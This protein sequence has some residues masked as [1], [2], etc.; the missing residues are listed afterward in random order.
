MDSVKSNLLFSN[1][2]CRI[3]EAY[4]FRL[5]KLVPVRAPKAHRGH[6]QL[7]YAHFTYFTFANN[8][9]LTYFTFAN[10]L[11]LPFFET[12]EGRK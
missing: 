3:S 5:F 11:Q 6:C 8:L 7:T 2:G 9:Q 10:N 1:V 4:I 12:T